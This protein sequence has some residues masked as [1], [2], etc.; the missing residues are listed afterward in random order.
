MM[1][2]RGGNNG[3]GAVTI[4]IIVFA[5]VIAVIAIIIAR[6]IAMGRDPNKWHGRMNC[7]RCGYIWHTR[8]ST[9]PACC[10]RCSTTL[11]TAVKG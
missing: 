2:A 6:L 10:P 7:I 3:S 4:G 5:A 9:P 1:L 8:Q 11:I